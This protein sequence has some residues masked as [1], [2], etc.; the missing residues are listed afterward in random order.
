MKAFAQCE[1][2]VFGMHVLVSRGTSVGPQLGTDPSAA[3]HSLLLVGVLSISS[4]AFGSRTA[5]PTTAGFPISLGGAA[6]VRQHRQGELQNRERRRRPP[7]DGGPS[8]PEV[9]V[10]PPWA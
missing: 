2:K 3:N 6:E 9:H 1:L 7:R 8:P 10:E 4:C 5:V